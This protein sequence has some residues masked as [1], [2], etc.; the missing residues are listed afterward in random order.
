MFAAAPAK[1]H[2][3]LRQLKTLE[4]QCHISELRTE[5]AQILPATLHECNA[6]SLLLIC[7]A[8]ASVPSGLVA[9]SGLKLTF[10]DGM[11]MR[12]TTMYKLLSAI[13]LASSALAFS[14]AANAADLSRPPPPVYKAPA[15]VAPPFSWTGFYIGGNV[16]AGWGRGEINDTVGFV[17][18]ATSNNASFIGGGQIG[19]NYQIGAFVIGA[20]AQFDWFANNSNS[21]PGVFLPAVGQTIR[22]SA[23]DRW[24]TTLAARAGWA[25]NTVL[26]YA[27]GGGGWVGAGNF[28][29]TNVGTGA[30]VALSNSNSNT[31][32]LAGA[33]VEW[34]FLPNWTVRAEYDFLGLSNNSWTVAVP[35]AAGTFTDTFSTRDRNIQMFTVGVNYLFNGF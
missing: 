25:I 33:G 12:K 23:N 19:G 34:A 28:A 18:F 11:T 35:T 21:G 24:V 17:N 31:G 5:L 1:R 9:K 14:F 26:L 30:S 2:S 20:E 22:V 6:H 27:K 4:F 7:R 15:V 3:S 16:G 32:W 8:P 13:A 29:V 10:R